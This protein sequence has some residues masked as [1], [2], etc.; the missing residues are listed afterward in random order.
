MTAS[1][2]IAR[3]DDFHAHLRQDDMLK[4]VLPH[5]SNVFHRALVM[6]NI[7]MPFGGEPGKPP[8]PVRSAADAIWY[9]QEILKATRRGGRKFKPFMA[10]ATLNWRIVSD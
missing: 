5:T 7:R 3:P 2:T 10:D 1:L 4:L 8:P 9:R 6:P